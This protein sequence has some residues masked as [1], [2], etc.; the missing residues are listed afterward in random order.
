MFAMI[1]AKVLVKIMERIFLARIVPR[2]LLISCQAEAYSGGYLAMP[3]KISF[4]YRTKYENMVKAKEKMALS[5]NPEYIAVAKIDL[6]QNRAKILAKILDKILP[7]SWKELFFL[8]CEKIR[9]C[10]GI[11]VR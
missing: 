4:G 10:F 6:W 8:N 5:W 7:I 11:F 3:E 1:L 9:Y 2:F